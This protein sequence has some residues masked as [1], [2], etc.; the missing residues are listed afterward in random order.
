MS[1]EDFV[2]RSRLLGHL[3]RIYPHMVAFLYYQRSSPT[4]TLPVRSDPEAGVTVISG[5]T[6]W[7]LG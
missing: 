4:T 6:T 2:S 1:S 3:T 5:W 7:E